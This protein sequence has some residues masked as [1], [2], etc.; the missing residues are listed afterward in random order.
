MRL[1][2]V[3]Q[4]LE[5]CESGTST[6][7]QLE[8]RFLPVNVS[9][10][11]SFSFL[12][13]C[14]CSCVAAFQAAAT[15]LSL[16]RLQDSC[17]FY[18]PPGSHKAGRPLRRRNTPDRTNWSPAAGAG[19]PPS[20]ALRASGNWSG[21]RS[22]HQVQA[23]SHLQRKMLPVTQTNAEEHKALSFPLS[24]SSHLCLVSVLVFVTSSSSFWWPLSPD[25]LSS[26]SHEFFFILSFRL[27]TTAVL[28][29]SLW[30]VLNQK[31]AQM[32]C[33]CWSAVVTFVSII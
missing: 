21:E 14:F 5:Q 13:L 2:L 22:R 8:L 29:L 20:A 3:H 18:E 12:S 26:K 6:N 23:G 27:S 9:V 4:R 17:W 25:F 19:A 16:E 33:L 28:S 32:W 11:D 10:F 7:I 24:C 31:T 15:N 30:N 1:Q